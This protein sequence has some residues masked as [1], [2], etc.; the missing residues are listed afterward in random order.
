MAQG[1]PDTVKLSLV[2]SFDGPD[3]T[4]DIKVSNYND[5]VGF[6]FGLNYDSD[7][8]RLKF[9]SSAINGF[10]ADQFM[11]NSKGNI[12]FFWLD[13]ATG[14]TLPDD[15]KLITLKFTPLQISSIGFLEISPKQLPFEFINKDLE[16]L[17][18]VSDFKE[19]TTNGYAISGKVVFDTN[20]NCIDDGQEQ[21]LA[22]WLVE[23]TDAGKTYYR[24]TKSD[25]SYLFTMPNGVYT[26]RLIPRNQYWQICDDAITTIVSG[27]DIGSQ[28][29]IANE[30]LPCVQIKTDIS[31]KSLRRCADNTYFLIYE[32]QG[33]IPAEDVKITVDYDSEFMQLVGTNFTDFTLS[34]DQITYNIGDLG[35]NVVDTIQLVLNLKCDN[36][37]DL[38]THCVTATASPNQPCV[39]PPDWSGAKLEVTKECDKINNVV[40]FSV[41]NSGAG[42]MKNTKTYIVT[43]DDVMR[44]PKP[45]KL[46][47]LQVEYIELPANGTTYRIF[48]TQDDGFPYASPVASV[49]MEGCGDDGNGNFSTGFVSLFE[50]SDRDLFI[51]TDCQQS[52]GFETDNNMIAFPLGYGD[53]HYIEKGTN[54]EYMVRFK[55]T[56]KDTVTTV[57]IKNNIPNT[58]DI[59]SLQMG[60]SSHPYSYRFNQER[61]LIITFDNLTLPNV[62]TN[63]LQSE[64]FIKYKIA[65]T[66]ILED[67]DS[68][69]TSS[70]ILY[71]Y[72]TPVITNKVFHTIGTNFIISG[73]EWFSS[74]LDISFYPNPIS[75]ELII[76]IKELVFINGSYEIINQFGQQ[77]GSGDMIQGK[78]NII[79]DHLPYGMY[80]FKINV[81]KTPIA[82]VK[83]IKL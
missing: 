52:I 4:V 3:L 16:S 13:N 29:F 18:V 56:E 31:T 38:Q 77:V 65:P 37:V 45:I 22:D 80:L 68:I 67:G 54:I 75:T 57:T 40:R 30:V 63:E 44:P 7:L 35:V 17:C 69:I 23:L 78:Q 39:I 32:N 82:T 10:G 28:D 50:E 21:G 81:N 9:V 27:D 62:L 70:R 15:T 2:T 1:C 14:E 41:L 20:N 26:I 79:C 12:R 71:D 46:D 43:E 48:A 61:D 19:F 60:S 24:N 49:A 36:T 83:L 25:G 33:T 47:Q 11:D 76:D 53:M 66:T 51:D 59:S 58:L 6:Q 34:N 73:T 72:S 5:I 55:N 42:N 74:P 8:I 64:G